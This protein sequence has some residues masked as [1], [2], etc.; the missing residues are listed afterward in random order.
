[1]RENSC[2]VCGEKLVVVEVC[3]TCADPLLVECQACNSY[4]EEY[5]HGS[6]KKII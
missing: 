2:R 6:C 5:F 1:M 4:Q 3:K